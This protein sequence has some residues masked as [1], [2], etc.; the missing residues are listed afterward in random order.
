LA[1]Y[2]IGRLFASFLSLNT[3]LVVIK[4]RLLGSLAAKIN[5]KVLARI[6]CSNSEPKPANHCLKL[7]FCSA[8]LWVMG[9]PFLLA[10]FLI[11]LFAW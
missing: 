3:G 7:G 9:S 10:F 1:L 11:V 6:S 8:C 5:R 2:L 4:R